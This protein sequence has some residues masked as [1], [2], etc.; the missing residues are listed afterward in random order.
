MRARVK[1]FAKILLNKNLEY[2]VERLIKKYKLGDRIIFRP[3]TDRVEEY[4]TACDVVVFPSMQAHQAR[5][6]YEAAIAK[7]PVVITDF[8]NTQEFLTE[9]N[10]WLFKRGDARMLAAKINEIMTTDVTERVE[11]NYC[12]AVL[13]NNLQALP[14]ELKELLQNVFSKEC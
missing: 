13:T 3:A 9:E 5:P 1:Y 10:G 7:K 12:K 11:R 6:V 8:E 14:L 4:F 2:K